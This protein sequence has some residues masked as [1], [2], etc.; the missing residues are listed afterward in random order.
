VRA[1]QAAGIAQTGL[2]GEITVV[3][4]GGLRVAILGFAPYSATASLLDLATARAL[5]QQADAKAG[6]VI[7]AIH[8]GAE[9]TDAQH[10]TG[11]EESYVGEDRGNAEAFAHM[12]VDAG[13]DLVLG[14]GPHVLRGMEIYHRRLIAYSLGNFAGYHNFGLDGVLGDS[15]VLHVRL[16]GKRRFPLGADHVGAARRGRDAGARPGGGGRTADRPALPRRPRI[17]GRPGGAGWPDR[18]ALSRPERVPL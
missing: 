4:A 17:A 18:A 5:I 15:A 3:R 10:V 16:T 7:V 14:S 9:G 6:I 8:A 2:P 1:L 13:A 11:A 12:A